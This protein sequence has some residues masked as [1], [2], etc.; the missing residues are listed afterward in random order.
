MR[1]TVF[2]LF[3]LAA[4]PRAQTAIPLEEALAVAEE[5]SLAVLRAD[6]DV[7]A[8]SASLQGVAD[9]RWPSLSFRAGGGQ[10]YGLAFDQTSGALTQATVES[11]N[12][13]VS[14]QYV[15]FDGFE[16]R[17]EQRAAEAGLREAELDRARTRQRARVAVL[18]GYL[19]VA[20]ADAAREVAEETVRVE[21]DLLEQIE[22]RVGYGDRPP[23]E[24]AQQQERLAAARGSVLAAER[25]RALA[26]ARLI[27][28]LGLDPAETYAFPSP[29]PAETGP[30]PALDALVQRALAQRPDLQAAETAIEAAEA[31]RQSARA[32][33]LPQVALGGYL[34]TS[35]TSA[36]TSGFPGQIGDNRTGSLSLN[37]S[38]PILDRGVT[39]Q[40][41]R[42]AEAQA[43]ALR[44]VETDT[45]RAIMLEVQEHTIRLEAL[46]AQIGLAEVRVESAMAARTAER[47]RYDGGETTLQAVS[48]LQARLDEART[49]L[50][51][52]RVQVQFERRL[53]A[54]SLGE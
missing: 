39:R 14:A 27:R 11:M 49:D 9:G 19:A 2:V 42:Q 44:A 25:D 29:S 32:S 10:R 15:V 6:A 54:L 28:L 8:Q 22:V 26:H 23:S 21:T 33:R 47:A 24:V 5:Q 38:L 41:V 35:Y 1:A 53:L 48:V 31:N 3:L 20:R 4:S 43:H 40:R 37:V 7:L 16:R 50:A 46:A 30:V 34:G 36:A 17:A 12:F 52:L 45:R 51:L 18:D 13:G